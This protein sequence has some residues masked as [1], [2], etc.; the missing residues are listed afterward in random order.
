MSNIFSEI[1]YTNSYDGIFGNDH[2]CLHINDNVF[3]GYFEKSPIEEKLITSFNYTPIADGFHKPYKASW[4]VY[5][6]KLLLGYVNGLINGQRLYT[7][8]IIPEFPD[9][10]ILFLYHYFSGVLKLTIQQKEILPNASN[11]INQN[12][13]SLLLTFKNGIL[14]TTEENISG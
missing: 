7:T 13:N 1:E 11:F 6:S 9:D 10:E 8:D 4:M 5:E 2:A 12:C 3:N 14:L